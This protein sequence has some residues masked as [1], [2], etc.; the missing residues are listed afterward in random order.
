V[1]P[2]NLDLAEETVFLLPIRGCQD[3]VNA[4]ADVTQ[5]LSVLEYT[6]TIY[7]NHEP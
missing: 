1:S 5:D 2:E 6:I 4:I 7:P 3:I